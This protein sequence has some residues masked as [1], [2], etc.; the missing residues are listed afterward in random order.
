M[1]TVIDI[2]AKRDG[3]ARCGVKHTEKTKTWP[4]DAFTPAQLEQLK[5]EPMLIVTVRNDDEQHT[6]PDEQVRQLEADL[7]I[8]VSQEA[9][10]RKQI[11]VLTAELEARHTGAAELTKQ[12]D[13]E[14][15]TVAGLTAELE[16][17]RKQVAELTEQLAATAKNKGK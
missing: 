6:G 15:Q 11:S 12:L 7:Q 13:T 8:L 14:R 16:A 1:A 17:A 10:A 3:F 5:A 2:T 9:E 4:I